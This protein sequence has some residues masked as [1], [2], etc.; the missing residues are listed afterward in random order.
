MQLNLN[1]AYELTQDI[2]C[3]SFSSFVPIG[4]SSNRFQGTLDGKGK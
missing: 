2:D 1:G 4:N 3:T